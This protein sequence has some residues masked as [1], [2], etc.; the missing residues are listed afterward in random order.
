LG[1]LEI[2]PNELDSIPSLST[3]IKLTRKDYVDPYPNTPQWVPPPAVNG[4]F[5]LFALSPTASMPINHI[6]IEYCYSTTKVPSPSASGV[7]TNWYV[8][9]WPYMLIDQQPTGDTP[10]ETASGSNYYAHL[11]HPDNRFNVNWFEL[12]TFLYSYTEDSNHNGRIDRIR[13]QAAFGL[14]GDF[15][16]D[17]GFAVYVEDDDSKEPYNVIGYRMV[18]EIATPTSTDLD[19]IF[20]LLEEKPYS[21][22]NAALFWK[23]TKNNSL[24]DRATGYTT[25]GKPEPSGSSDPE[26]SK[27]VTCDTAPP[28]INYALT[29]PGHAQLFFQVSEPVDPGLTVSA[30]TTPAGTPAPI[31]G[32]GREFIMDFGSPYGVSDLVSGAALFSVTGLEDKAVRVEDLHSPAPSRPYYFMYPEPKYPKNYNYE[33]DG[34]SYQP[35]VSVSGTD[36]PSVG[37]EF[38]YPP[39]KSYD[40]LSGLSAPSVN[41]RVTDVLV[42]VPPSILK[43]DDYFVWPVWARY[44]LP[45]NPDQPVLGVEGFWG[46]KPTDSGLIWEFDG[47]KYIE[48][49]ESVMQV[50]LNDAVSTTPVLR[51]AAGISDR[52]RARALD[53]FGYGHGNT[54][55]WLPRASDASDDSTSVSDSRSRIGFTNMVPYF[56]PNYANNTGVLSSHNL[57]QYEFTPGVD[58]FKSG[59]TIEFF[60]HIPVSHPDTTD[61][62][63]ARLDIKPGAAIP[64]N[65]YRLVKPFAFDVHDITRQR[66]GV[67]ILNNVINPSGGESCYVQYRLEK[68]GQVTVQV[69]S[70]DGSMVSVLYRGHRDA[71]E[72]RAAWNGTNKSGRAVARG[73]YFIRVVGPDIDEIRKVMVVR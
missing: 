36:M 21:D 20:V 69:F 51:F 67:T 5:W 3:V 2:T 45:A 66:S 11:T 48:E 28:R 24:K 22:T 27:G 42:S 39:N 13:L 43:Q 52:Y 26:Q 34:A 7:M 14:N 59:N 41:H 60:F 65:W 61:L 47:K 58:G 54:G 35:Y 53:S 38:V 63:A 12:D 10:V 15:T 1:S 4:H 72:Y 73:M 6:V 68:G 49:R 40:T 9:A 19:S 32:T 18:E 50:K 17:G 31:G 8:S 33:K 23:V 44:I 29:L 55:L 25:I 57:Y 46:Q 64:S 71:G 70:L 62:P 37:N 56:S 16:S 30:I